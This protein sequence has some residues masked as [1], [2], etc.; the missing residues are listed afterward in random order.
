MSSLQV[1]KNLLTE[2]DIA[3]GEGLLVQQRQGIPFNLHKVR[4]IYPVSSLAELNA[5]DPTKHPK[6]ALIEQGAIV[7]YA[8]DGVAY[9]VVSA[10]DSQLRSAL[11]VA[12]KRFDSV[13]ALTTD[14]SLVAGELLTT[15]LTLW[16]VTDTITPVAYGSRFLS[17]IGNVYA[18]DFDL[19]VSGLT[20]QDQNLAL[21]IE[22]ANS[23]K[24]ACI[25]PSGSILIREVPFFSDSKITGDVHRETVLIID[26]NI[27]HNRGLY[28]ERPTIAECGVD[29][30]N[31]T[32]KAKTPG[33]GYGWTMKR[34]AFAKSRNIRFI[35]LARGENFYDV[36]ISRFVEHYYKACVVGGYGYGDA[37]LNI[38]VYEHP[39]SRNCPDTYLIE[40]NPA[41]DNAS[42]GTKWVDGDFEY[43]AKVFNITARGQSEHTA[44]NC[45]FEG[46]SA[47][48]STINEVR[49]MAGARLDIVRPKV[50]DVSAS[51]APALITSD[52]TGTVRVVGPVGKQTAAFRIRVPRAGRYDGG[53]ELRDGALTDLPSNTADTVTHTR[54]TSSFCAASKAS[55]SGYIAG[56]APAGARRVSAFDG[57]SGWTSGAGIAVTDPIGGN[58]AFEVTS[59]AR[60]ACTIP[61]SGK[62][63][64]QFWALCARNDSGTIDVPILRSTG[65]TSIATISLNYNGTSDWRL[66]HAIIDAD[67][68]SGFD[69]GI[70]LVFNALSGIRYWGQQVT[71]GATAPVPRLPNGLVYPAGAIVS[72]DQFATS[73]GQFFETKRESLGATSTVNTQDLVSATDQSG[74]KCYEVTVITSFTGTSMAEIYHVTLSYGLAAVVADAVKLISTSTAGTV[75]APRVSVG[76]SSLSASSAKAIR[77]TVN[78]FVNTLQIKVR[79]LW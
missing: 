13:A 26:D 65:L 33:I 70:T 29:V 21:A 39:V 60:M 42:Y 44:E 24:A 25:L 35:D 41:N 31:L 66:F 30:S 17:P 73:L 8:W 67:S 63:V 43:N 10:G 53:N 32:F 37:G 38:N 9:A 74:A 79:P 76:I 56:V 27:S 1:E 20:V 69:G 54:V 49:V 16:Q 18:Q 11:G 59:Q 77:F 57:L 36:L 47:S 19:D 23:A 3:Y 7:F 58:N 71:S 78:T 50:G 61:T 12:V 64:V 55:I 45:T 28:L 4:G 6:A 22:S 72:G 34:V 68:L 15:G 40:G 75:A 2:E 52:S 5:L 48:P 14:L 46:N 62:S 51:S